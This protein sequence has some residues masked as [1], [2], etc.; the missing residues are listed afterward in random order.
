M[1]ENDVYL[2]VSLKE[3]E[4]KIATSVTLPSTLKLTLGKEDKTL[5]A[6]VVP[7][8]TTDIPT[9]SIVDGQ[10]VISIQTNG[11]TASVHAL[12]V[13][14]ATVKV[15]YNSNVSDECEVTVKEE[16][17][18][19][20]LDGVVYEFKEDL[21]TGKRSKNITDASVLKEIFDTAS[22]TTN[23]IS[24]VSSLE[25]VYGAGYGGSGENAWY[26]GNCLKLGTTSVNGTFALELDS[27][28]NYV[29]I[30]G[31]V[32][33]STCNIQVGDSSSSEWTTGI[34]DGKTTT[35]TASD[36]EVVN[37]TAIDSLEMSSITIYFEGTDSIKIAITNK[38][39]LFI[40]SIEFGYD[41]S[42]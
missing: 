35:I 15:T 37:K 14:I 38:K 42:K 39:P 40:T 5:S 24:S 29:I 12:K 33:A 26:L 18:N 6:T 10:D 7:S 36:M 20:G 4:K 19:P 21:G 16:S 32:Y 31:Y 3:I 13:G 25:N 11:N 30:T 22:G 41:E 1:P 27:E 17:T 23:I 2:T 28:V 9:W 34:E 8:D